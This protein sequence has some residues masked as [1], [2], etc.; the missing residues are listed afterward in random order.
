MNDPT[1]LLPERLAQVRDQHST[2]DFARALKERAGLSVTHSM[3]ARYEQGTSPPA[4]YVAAVCRAFDVKPAWLL[5]GYGPRRWNRTEGRTRNMLAAA[6]WMREF[7]L[8]LERTA[9]RGE[10]LEP[11]QA[12]AV[13]SSQV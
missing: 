8:A 2:R 6:A 13:L 1:D 7:S 11:Q 4:R 5:T 12:A 3:V 10:V 9:M